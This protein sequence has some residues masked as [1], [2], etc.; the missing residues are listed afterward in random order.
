VSERKILLGEGVFEKLV[1]LY[2]KALEYNV[3]DDAWGLD[4]SLWCL[5]TQRGFTYSKACFWSPDYQSEKRGLIGMVNLGEEL[6]RFA[7]LNKKEIG[8]L[9]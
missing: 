9:Y 8:P 7:E 5:E 4:G 3:K 6:W 1:A 2:E